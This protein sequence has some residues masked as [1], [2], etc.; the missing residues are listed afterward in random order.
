MEFN[1]VCVEELIMNVEARMYVAYDE[2]RC[3]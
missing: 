3:A 2:T 1:G